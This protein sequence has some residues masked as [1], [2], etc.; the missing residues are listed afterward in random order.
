M[1]V[2]KMW[3]G[4]FV[5]ALFLGSVAP[6]SSKAENIVYDGSNPGMLQTNPVGT[7]TAI[8]PTGLSGNTV[9]VTASGP[10]SIFGGLA[11]GNEDVRNNTVNVSNAIVATIRGGHSE[12]GGIVENNTVNFFSGSTIDLSG[13]YSI[14]GNAINNSVILDGGSVHLEV[15]GGYSSGGD[16]IG[17]TVIVYDA[18]VGTHVA[19]GETD[20]GNAVKNT[21]IVNA[22]SVADIYGGLAFLAGNAT[23][24][25]V[26]L[27]GGTITGDVW[28][29]H[30]PAGD[31]FTGNTLN[32]SNRF[33]FNSLNNFEFLN[34]NLPEGFQAN[35]PG[36]AMLTVAATSLGGASTVS[37][38]NVARGSSFAVGDT[39]ALINST[40]VISGSLA[41]NTAQGLKGAALVYD[42]DVNLAANSLTATL[43]GIS[44][45]PQLKGPSQGALAGTALINEGGNLAAEQGISSAVDAT[46]QKNPKGDKDCTGL[47][48]FSALR[49]GFSRYNTGSHVDMTSFSFL[50]GLA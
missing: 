4:L 36:D 28:G 9:T 24:N 25:I 34:F 18:A 44:A 29:G 41:K 38:I 26:S 17:N 2:S 47:I 42:W 49:A 11:L 31:A 16:A 35:N 43:T 30:A 5:A 3:V 19:G 14:G 32:V 15:S 33:T 22:G 6:G 40:G 10:G 48:G 13:G 39:V 8:Y 50:A 21:V 37:S 7:G 1:A 45:N 12:G 20:I 27:A 46:C 23:D